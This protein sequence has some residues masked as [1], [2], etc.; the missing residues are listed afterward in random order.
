MRPRPPLVEGWHWSSLDLSWTIPLSWWQAWRP[1]AIPVGGRDSHREGPDAALVQPTTWAES[2][3]AGPS[4]I[5]SAL[6]GGRDREQAQ[7]GVRE[8]GVRGDIVGV[9]GVVRG[10]ARADRASQAVVRLRRGELLEDHQG[11][12][13]GGDEALV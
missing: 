12:G 6:R 1:A 10:L 13:L 3:D 2:P 5:W 8:S 9:V 7:A 11:V 4:A